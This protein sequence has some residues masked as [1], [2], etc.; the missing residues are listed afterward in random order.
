MPR[1]DYRNREHEFPFKRNR[2]VCPVSYLVMGLREKGA[3]IV[4]AGEKRYPTKRGAFLNKFSGPLGGKIP[5]LC[6]SSRG[7]STFDLDQFRKKATPRQVEQFVKAFSP[8]LHHY[9]LGAD[10]RGR[11]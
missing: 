6:L 2:P 11:N 10:E 8:F 7:R 5:G 3:V 4:L 9:V 1:D